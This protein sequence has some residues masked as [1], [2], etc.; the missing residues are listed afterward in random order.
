[1]T[2]IIEASDG[3]A[4]SRLDADQNDLDIGLRVKFI[5]K[6]RGVSQAALGELIRCLFQQG[7]KYERGANRICA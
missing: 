1:M 2:D 4:G 6:M 7:Q 3:A 5:R